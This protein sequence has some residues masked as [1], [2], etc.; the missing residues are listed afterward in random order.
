M[1][2]RTNG[3][4]AALIAA[5]GKGERLGLGPKAFLKLGEKTLLERAVAAIAAGVDEVIVAVPSAHLDGARAL[6]PAARV[7]PGRDT[8]Q[9]TVLAML[10]QTDAQVVLVHDAA[11]PFLPLR[12]VHE[13]RE[14]AAAKGAVS[15]SR[16]VADTLVNAGSGEPVAREWPRAVRAPPGFWRVLLLQGPQEAARNG[17][18]AADDTALVRALG[19]EMDWCEGSPWL[20]KIT[21]PG[22]FEFARTLAPAWEAAQ[23]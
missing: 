13:L 5:A 18:A 7:V 12:V 3:R 21:T 16:R 2:R 22:D 4:C 8:R 23:Q 11:R 14:A 1:N 17:T 15:A 6:L 10:E 19:H 20:C 9:G